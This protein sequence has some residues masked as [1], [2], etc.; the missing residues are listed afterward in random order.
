MQYARGKITNRDRARQ[1]KDFTGLC[2]GNITPTDIDGMIEYHGKRYMFIELKLEGVPVPSGQRLA[3]ERLVDDLERAGK[4]AICIIASHAFYDT[5]SEIDVANANVTEYR[6]SGKW[7]TVEWPLTVKHL[8]VDFLNNR[9]TQET[10]AVVLERL[11]TNWKQVIEL[12]P[13]DTKRTPTAAILRSPSVSP[14]AIEDNTIVLSFR[15]PLHKEQLEKAENRTVA[16]KIISNFLGHPC[17]VRCVYE[18]EHDHLLKAALKMGAQ[19]IESED[20]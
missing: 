15:Y 9:L 8:I 18:P 12:A 3:L 7:H 11:K 6:V 16:E 17:H 1:I 19:I 5:E 4:R 2:F 13:Q 20:E 10:N 14:V